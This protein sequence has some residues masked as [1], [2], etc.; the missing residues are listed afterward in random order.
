MEIMVKVIWSRGQSCLEVWQADES[1]EGSKSN[2]FQSTYDTV[3]II[4]VPEVKMEDLW[5]ML[6][7]LDVSNFIR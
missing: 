1:T 7:E 5:V 3:V 2:S 4:Q 6:N